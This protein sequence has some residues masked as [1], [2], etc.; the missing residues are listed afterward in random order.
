[1][2]LRKYSTAIISGL[3]VSAAVLAVEIKGSVE[4]IQQLL[5]PPTQFQDV[6][7]GKIILQN[8]IPTAPS[9]GVVATSSQF[10]GTIQPSVN[11]AFDIGSPTKSWKDIYASGTAYLGA[12]T[13]S[14][15]VSGTSSFTN[16][17]TSGNTQVGDATTDLIALTGSV[18]T[19]VIPS[20]DLTY[21]LGSATRRWNNAYIGTLNAVVALNTDEPLNIGNGTATTTINGSTTS[22]FAGAIT[23]SGNTRLGDATTD[24]IDVTGR[25]S[26]SLL[27]NV[28]NALDF[29]GY[30]NAYRDIYASSSVYANRILARA[31]SAA[32][33]GISF[34]AESDD[35]MSISAEDGG[36]HTL[37][38]S[39]GGG[40]AVAFDTANMFMGGGYSIVGTL[41]PIILSGREADGALAENLIVGGS[42]RLTTVGARVAS[43]Q[44]GTIDRS[45]EEAYFG[46]GPDNTRL[47]LIGYDIQTANLLQAFKGGTTTSTIFWIDKNGGLG[48]SSTVYASSTLI[49]GINKANEYR[50]GLL[51]GVDGT[52]NHLIQYASSSVN[53]SLAIDFTDAGLR[54]C[55]TAPYAFVQPEFNS[56]ADTQLTCDPHTVSGTGMTIECV[57]TTGDGISETTAQDATARNVN[58][59]IGCLAP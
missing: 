29:G 57:L 9:D 32:A 55:N 54:D 42:P 15:S 53:G 33:P 43:F 7:A 56:D 20:I 24:L 17:S 2:N 22:T 39:I 34:A 10:V 12:I 31:G 41:S 6:G 25:F 19:N 48:A 28:N 11:N 13:L 8:Y 4:E 38:L 3:L 52:M 47:G 45:G 59:M 46:A 5:N 16:L 37:T 1:M 26:T 14:G 18:S 40:Q 23:I 35:G 30:G 36:Y 50:G 58:W 27:P 44:N 51:E 21:D 49:A